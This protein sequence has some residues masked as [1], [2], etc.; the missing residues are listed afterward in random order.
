MKLVF[1]DLD[2]TLLNTLQ[3]LTNSVNYAMD[4]LRLNRYDC[5][6]VKAMIGNGVAKLMERAVTKEHFELK[7]EAL[8]L[9]REYYLLRSG[10]NTAPYR[11]VREMLTDLKRKGYIVAV[12]TN[13]DENVAKNL[14]AKH[15]G[16]LI[17][18][19][20][21]TTVDNVTKP[22]PQSAKELLYKLNIEPND[23][24]Y[25]GDSDV[26]VATADNLGVECI[27]A[28]WGFRDYEFLKEHGAKHFA[29]NPLDVVNSIERLKARNSS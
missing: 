15:F 26:D 24:V 6:Q 3:D 19:V 22:N 9:Q 14:C 2:G 28:L 8:R 11:G 4:E 27:S 23:V 25:C 17:D 20:C 7:G 1:F 10:D 21:G 16:N 29:D 5:E 12:H 13:K 18:Y